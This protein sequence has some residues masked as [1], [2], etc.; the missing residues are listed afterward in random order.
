M[1]VWLYSTPRGIYEYEGVSTTPK[2]FLELSGGRVTLITPMAQHDLGRYLK[3]DG[4]WVWI[5]LSGHTCQLEWSL[6]TLSVK[7]LDVPTNS[8]KAARLFIR[9]GIFGDRKGVVKGAVPSIDTN[10]SPQK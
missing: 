3:S 7:D 10:S 2:S 9:P 1:A 8:F 6:M 5:T 4:K